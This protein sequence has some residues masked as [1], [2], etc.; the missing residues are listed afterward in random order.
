MA[1]ARPPDRSDAG[2]PERWAVRPTAQRAESWTDGPFDGPSHRP[3]DRRSERRSQSWIDP[4]PEESSDR[5][6]DPRWARR[7][8]WLLSSLFVADRTSVYG[9]A[10]AIQ[11]TLRRWVGRAVLAAFVALAGIALLREGR[12][13][14]AAAENGR[15]VFE[16]EGANA[17]T[18][19]YA[20]TAGAGADDVRP[21]LVEG[22][23]D[24]TDEE[25]AALRNEAD[26]RLVAGATEPGLAVVL[27][28]GTRRVHQTAFTVALEQPGRPL[29][30][31][32]GHTEPDG[33]APPLRL[34][35]GLSGRFDVTLR[36]PGF[37]PARALGVELGSGVA[38]VDFSAGGVTP[39]RAGD[40]DG[41][42]RIGT[43]DAWTWLRR[44]KSVGGGW[45]ADL[46]G[47]GTVS[48][49]DLRLLWANRTR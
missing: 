27:R 15:G 42:E 24:A 3:A 7:A 37:L 9:H 19:A 45:G 12:A 38:I 13:H 48:S 26:A 2:R 11:S 21:A 14:R 23:D 35:P 16:A 25:R 6:A 49:A 36:V 32:I 30:P 20:G 33:I 47:D 5:P 41:D 46:D 43:R 18:G 28:L 39:L 31:L 10:A 34:P 29:V 8:I 22:T 44:R 4:W 17:F 40:L 1:P